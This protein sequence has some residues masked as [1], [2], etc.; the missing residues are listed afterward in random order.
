MHGMSAASLKELTGLPDR[1]HTLEQQYTILSKEFEDSKQL[2]ALYK[3][4]QER[5]VHKE[6]YSSNDKVVV[7]RVPPFVISREDR[8][9]KFNREFCE[10]YDWS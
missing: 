10:T 5:I 1:I 3:M 6:S 4:F 8:I 7:P 9:V 2:Q